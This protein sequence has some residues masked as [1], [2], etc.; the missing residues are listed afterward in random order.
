MYKCNFC[1]KL[2]DELPDP[3]RCGSCQGRIFMKVRSDM[4]RRVKVR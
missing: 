2:Y 3:L 1:G 4:V